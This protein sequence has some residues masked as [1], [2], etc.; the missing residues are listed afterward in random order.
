MI[1]YNAVKFS[2][3]ITADTLRYS[4]D[5]ISSSGRSGQAQ[6]LSAAHPRHGDLNIHPILTPSGPATVTHP[7][8]SDSINVDDLVAKLIS[9]QSETFEEQVKRFIQPSHWTPSKLPEQIMK[10]RNP[11]PLSSVSSS[12]DGSTCFSSLIQKMPSVGLIVAFQNTS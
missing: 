6:L 4:N 11:Y 10:P 1:N 9:S 7:H 8:S 3:I 5:Q 12:P 2:R